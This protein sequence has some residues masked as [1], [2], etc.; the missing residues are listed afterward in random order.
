[1]QLIIS[2]ISSGTLKWLSILLLVFG[3][4]FSLYNQHRQIVETEKNLALQEYNNKQL[5]QNIKDKEIYLQQMEDISKHKSK[6]INELQREED[7]R[8]TVIKN[9][10]KIIEK[11][12]KEGH[13]RPSSQILKDTFRQ[14]EKMK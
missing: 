11:H 10:T 6:I 5:R 2:L 14:L 13:D 4:L 9:V 3:L 1:M 8:K 7:N 12:K